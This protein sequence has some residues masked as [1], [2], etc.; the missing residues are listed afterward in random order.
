MSGHKSKG[1]TVLIYKY[2]IEVESVTHRRIGRYNV[3]T[4]KEKSFLSYSMQSN[5]TISENEEKVGFP[6]VCFY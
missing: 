6:S 1:G 3:V 2:N 5:V 4:K